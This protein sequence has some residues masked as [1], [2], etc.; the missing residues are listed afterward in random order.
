MSGELVTDY[1]FYFHKSDN[2]FETGFGAHEKLKTY[3]LILKITPKGDLKSDLVETVSSK[4]ELIEMHRILYILQQV[5][6]CDATH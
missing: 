5:N 1:S 6:G 4:Y 2:D 3:L